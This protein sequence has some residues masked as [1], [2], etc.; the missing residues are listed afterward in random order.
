MP[1][2]HIVLSAPSSD[3][4][5][6]QVAQRLTDLTTDILGKNRALTAVRVEFANPQHW[7]IGGSCLGDPPL[8]SFYLEAKVTDGTNTAAQKA[9]FIAEVFA[10][11]EGVMGP[12]APA[13][14]TVV[15]E[16]PADA[17][18]YQGQT[19]AARAAYPVT[20]P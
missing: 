3:T 15:Q 20:A 5:A 18:G 11:L 8:N 9:R 14:Y 12:L 1:Y 4:T 7:T 17:W 13:S 10:A 2:L 16:M 19:Q 6:Q